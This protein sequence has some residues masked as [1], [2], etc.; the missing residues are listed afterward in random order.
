MLNL[1]PNRIGIFELK[2]FGN[3]IRLMDVEK[4]FCIMSNSETERITNEK[5]I[6]NARGDVLII[7]LGIGYILL[8]IQEKQ[9]VTSITV[10]EK[11][12]E[13][14]QLVAPQLSLNSK[15][16]IIQGDL[17][18]HS[19]S[20]DTKFDTLF[21]DIY[22]KNEFELKEWFVENYGKYCRDENSYIDAWLP[23]H[24]YLEFENSKVINIHQEKIN[25]NC[26]PTREFKLG[27]E[28][29]YDIFINKFGFIQSNKKS[30]SCT[31]K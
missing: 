22:G 11:Y 29:M 19:F 1:K 5:I 12:L 30:V 3:L 25:N 6:Q 10:V 28:K 26:I 16:N 23:E 27:D 9:D 18:T 24:C 20:D 14:I 8:P 15:V 17:F 4:N 13:V 21:C 7:G 31:N 2:V